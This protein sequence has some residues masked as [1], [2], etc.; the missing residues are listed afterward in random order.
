MYRKALGMQLRLLV[1]RREF[2]LSLLIM[3]LAALAPPLLAAVRYFGADI[4]R[5]RSA[6]YYFLN[7]YGENWN[8]LLVSAPLCV[9]YAFADSFYTDRKQNVLSPVLLRISFRSYL[10]S[11]LTVVVVSSFML[12][13]VP[14][15]V[16]MLICLIQ[17]PAEGLATYTNLASYDESGALFLEHILFRPLFFRSP[18]LYCA[19]FAVI[20]SVYYAAV[21]AL[22]FAVSLFVKRGRAW[23]VCG[24]FILTV[25]FT[26]VAWRLRTV[27]HLPLDP[28]AY[29]IAFDTEKDKHIAVLAAWLVLMAAVTAFLLR[30]F[31]RRMQSE[32]RV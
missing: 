11:K 10:L 12:V 8:Y 20:A 24:F 7:F 15:A 16:N 2:W 22:V 19:V 18:Y 31:F 1:N 23:L 21:S 9:C 30:R 5:L 14:L 13:L 28:N 3:F 26:N 27:T 29:I 25:V 17:F 32:P 4:H 6:Y